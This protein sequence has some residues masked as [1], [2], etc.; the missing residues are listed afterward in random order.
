MFLCSL[1]CETEAEHDIC[2]VGCYYNNLQPGIIIGKPLRLL[3]LKTFG[4]QHL[5]SIIKP[6][7]LPAGPNSHPVTHSQPPRVTQTATQHISFTLNHQSLWRGL[8]Q[9]SRDKS[10]PTS[11]PSYPVTQKATQSLKH[12]SSHPEKDRNSPQGEQVRATRLRASYLERFYIQ[13]RR[14][15]HDRHV[16]CC[17]SVTKIEVPPAKKRRGTEIQYGDQKSCNAL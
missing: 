16:K 7:A 2:A 8:I 1:L 4:I 3:Q 6:L 9:S 5:P 11:H 13:R 14:P 12:Q 17:K 10:H 15:V